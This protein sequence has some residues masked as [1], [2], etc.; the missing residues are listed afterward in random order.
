MDSNISHLTFDTIGYSSV[1]I[2]N[3]Y[4]FDFVIDNDDIIK[5]IYIYNILQNCGKQ[6]EEIENLRD[7]IFTSLSKSTDFYIDLISAFQISKYDDSEYTVPSKN[8]Y[9]KMDEFGNIQ[10]FDSCLFIPI[11][12]N[13]LNSTAYIHIYDSR[14]T[15]K[16]RLENSK[17][18]EKYNS[19]YGKYF[20]RRVFTH[21]IS[22][23]K[24]HIDM[25]LNNIDSVKKKI[26][27]MLHTSK[28]T[29]IVFF[30]EMNDTKA[31]KFSDELKKWYIENFKNNINM[32]IEFIC[33]DYF[34]EYY[35]NRDCNCSST[36]LY[37]FPNCNFEIKLP[38]NTF[39][40]KDF[41]EFKKKHQSNFIGGIIYE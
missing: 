20:M 10:I 37:K 26:Y 14:E 3:S 39:Y 18:G 6:L 1:G 5:V 27:H 33:G 21:V 11:Y 24:I 32:R 41:I 38:K 16:E 9:V 36:E 13:M 4:N 23:E 7:N 2:C 12:L 30:I 17:K 8:G 40:T 29:D 15:Q 22:G 35:N 25:I 34:K 31:I 19:Y 28:L